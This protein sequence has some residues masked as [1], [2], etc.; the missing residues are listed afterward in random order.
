MIENLIGTKIKSVRL[1]NHLTQAEFAEKLCASQG[2][3]SSIENG[4]YKP[5]EKFLMLV[6][7]LFNIPNDY[8]ESNNDCRIYQGWK[9]DKNI[10][11]KL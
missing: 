11:Q 2:Y 6:K 8:F 7:T 4:I 10:R 3:I 9:A 1:D 5:S